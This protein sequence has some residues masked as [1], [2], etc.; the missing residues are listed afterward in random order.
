MKCI[1]CN[2]EI[3]SKDIWCHT[4]GKK[5]IWGTYPNNSEDLV[6]S[7][8]N[9]NTKDDSLNNSSGKSGSNEFENESNKNLESHE[10]KANSSP[11]VEHESSLSSS[12][13]SETAQK[14]ETGV[15]TDNTEDIIKHLGL[16]SYRFVCSNCKS[17]VDVTNASLSTPVCKCKEKQIF[18][19]NDT[20]VLQIHRI[21][22]FSQFVSRK[23]RVLIDGV[24]Y[25]CWGV[26]STTDVIAKSGEINIEAIFW[27]YKE[28]KV[29]KTKPGERMCFDISVALNAWG[30]AVGVKID[31]K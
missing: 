9:T 15:K 27:K 1:L 29:F 14:V 26:G 7:V 30:G 17:I 19:I 13:K 21:G 25:G 18:S 20:S 31:N 28:K 3:D 23:M 12:S 8:V 4:C 5:Q 6:R 16:S 2:N 24:D 22:G 10:E 11:T